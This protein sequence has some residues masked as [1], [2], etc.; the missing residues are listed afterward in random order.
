MQGKH[1]YSWELFRV[2]LLTEDQS[3]SI[4]MWADL[5]PAHFGPELNPQMQTLETSDYAALTRY[6]TKNNLGERRERSDQTHCHICWTGVHDL[7]KYEHY[8]FI[9]PFYSILPPDLN[10]GVTLFLQNSEIKPCMNITLEKKKK[11]D[12]SCLCSLHF[13]LAE[14]WW[15]C[16][17]VLKHTGVIENLFI[18]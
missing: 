12:S 9:K 14:W 6:A 4:L 3:F 17:A 18:S 15:K 1:N 5:T 8:S 11:H 10:L 2:T 16:H 13:H 7:E